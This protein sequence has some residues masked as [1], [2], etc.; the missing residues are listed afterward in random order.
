MQYVLVTLHVALLGLAAVAHATFINSMPYALLGGGLHEGL[1]ALLAFALLALDGLAGPK[2]V[3]L[4]PLVLVLLCMVNLVC[5]WGRA[6]SQAAVWRVAGGFCA[7]ILAALWAFVARLLPL[8]G[9][10]S[11]YSLGIWFLLSLTMAFFL[12]P[13]LGCSPLSRKGYG[14]LL[15]LLWAAGLCALWADYAAGAWQDERLVPLA[16]FSLLYSGLF[17]MLF[18]LPAQGHGSLRQK[19]SF[20]VLLLCGLWAVW[21]L[22]PV[23]LIPICC[24]LVVLALQAQVARMAAP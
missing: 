19:I 12:Q 10:V 15:C 18:R 16:L 3:R 14:A 9:L 5:I 2:A 11:P 20:V 13:R 8:W 23:L 24:A 1:A 21:G 7:L 4:V 6:C 17:F 22:M